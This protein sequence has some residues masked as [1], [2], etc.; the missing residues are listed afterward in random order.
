MTKKIV[1]FDALSDEAKEKARQW[2]RDG[3]DFPMLGSHLTNVI[4]EKLEEK[5]FTVYGKYKDG[6]LTGSEDLQILYSLSC[7]QGD[8]VSFEA[9]L[10][11]DGVTYEVKQSGRYVHEFTLDVTATKDGKEVDVPDEA[12]EDI[13]KACKETELA[14][15]D[16]IDYENSDEYID[17]TMEANEY[18]FTLE[19]ERMDA[20]N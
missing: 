1:F 11:R 17:E 18:T 6:A 15:Y 13:R 5:G 9:T 10:E 2:Y 4:K 7:S 20:D 8:G 16:S 19:G 12:M 14:G 3:N